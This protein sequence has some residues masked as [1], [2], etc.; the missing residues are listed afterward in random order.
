MNNKKS[1][2]P[3]QKKSRKKTVPGE[4][5]SLDGSQRKTL[6]STAVLFAFLHWALLFILQLENYFFY[7]YRP[8]SG[9]LSPLLFALKL[10]FLQLKN[11]LFASLLG[12]VYLGMGQ[13]RFSQILYFFLWIGTAL[14]VILN[15][16]YFK[17]FF[18]HIRFNPQEGGLEGLS[19]LLGSFIA[20][21]DLV[22]YTN[23]IIIISLFFLILF[24]F[25]RPP[26]FLF[27]RLVR[28]GSSLHLP[29]A[30]LVYF[31][32][33]VV[34]VLSVETHSLE[35]HPLFTLAWSSRVWWMRSGAVE[36]KEI[37]DLYRPRY[38]KFSADPLLSQRL[39]MAAKSLRSRKRKPNILFLVLESVGALQILPD[40]KPNPRVTPHLAA[41]A[42]H[43]LIFDTIYT[44]FPGTSRSH[45]PLNTGGPTVTWSSVYQEH[46]Y[47]YQG[48]TLPG[49][50]KKMGYTTGGYSCGD[51][52]FE[53]L[54]A[55]YKRLGYDK[56]VDY[57]MLSEAIKEK[58]R[59]HSWG[60]SEDFFRT[61]ILQWIDGIKKPFFVQFLTIST[62]HPYGVPEGYRG[63]SS[64]TSRE[65][66][67]YNSL[68][69][70][71]SVIGRFIEAFKKR[72]L[73][74]DTILVL[75]GDH[76]QAFGKLHERNFTHRNYLY[77]E[78][79]RTFFWV[80]DP[81]KV[82][83]GPI[84]SHQVGQIGDIFPSLIYLLKG[85]VPKTLG[86]NLFSDYNL[87]NVF[88]HKSAGSEMWGLRDGKWKF[89][90]QQTGGLYELYNLKDDPAEQTN[91]ASQYPEQ[92]RLYHDMCAYWYVKIDMDYLKLL[93]D[94]P[95]PKK[96]TF[97]DVTT[98]GP[99]Q[100]S[101]GHFEK[102]GSEEV[103][104]ERTSF[105]PYERVAI[106]NVWF[107]FPEK[108]MIQ[109]QAFSP[110]GKEHS[111]YA[112]SNPRW[113]TSWFVIKAPLPLETGKW[114]VVLRDREKKLIFGSFLVNSKVPLRGPLA[115]RL[116]IKMIFAVLPVIVKGKNLLRSQPFFTPFDEIRILTFWEKQDG[117]YKIAYHFRE[118]GGTV[119]SFLKLS[120]GSKTVI[121]CPL[122]LP[123]K[124]GKWTVSLST[125]DRKE[126]GAI[127]FFVKEK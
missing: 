122:S 25:F 72:G 9:F 47:Y 127:S 71:D 117:L 69:Y 5:P 36:P 31:T 108:R 124:K 89:I 63:P 57:T 110:S 44:T 29:A 1:E 112:E 70:N 106:K 91:L 107:S 60:V 61:E 18:D 55:F 84:V 68:H 118:P 87:R 74:Q 37:K 120:G 33:S 3:E 62:H 50:I 79:I 15:Q 11:L 83:T 49:E 58:N 66:R 14:Y 90:S 67:Y 115:K 113:H 81:Q 4:N 103:L 24:I 105:N 48:P 56:Y 35:K 2:P 76:G 102:K 82:H 59:I 73:W 6:I 41:L 123:M 42:E 65:E 22:F 99:K 21:L 75:T 27:P 7:L 16:I 92:V 64:G 80:I 51:I 85:P 34:F 8:E 95:P 78:N 94:R 101:F 32:F 39:E 104:I 52:A 111:F 86:Q 96:L 26:L 54:R 45:I 114:T 116:K 98:F 88:F 20:E 43:S 13:G 30:I 100:I 77:D 119:Y 93:K 126:L 19:A 97:R 23:L 46:D 38:G 17:L 40:G 125:P 109:F 12:G 53:N 10:P 28:I 121:H